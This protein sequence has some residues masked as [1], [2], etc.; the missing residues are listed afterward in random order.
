[1]FFWEEVY[2]F[3]QTPMGPKS[4]EA[5]ITGNDES[6]QVCIAHENYRKGAD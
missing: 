4:I 1:M 6:S 2:N 5:T 3:H